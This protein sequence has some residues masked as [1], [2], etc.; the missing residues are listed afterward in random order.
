MNR[1]ITIF[2]PLTRAYD[3]A[4]IY[5][6]PDNICAIYPDL[7]KHRTI[8]DFVNNRIAVKEC[9]E[10]IVKLAKLTQELNNEITTGKVKNEELNEITIGKVESEELYES[11]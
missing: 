10:S 5:A 1:N 9:M 7:E 6:N 8:V 2:I 11:S 3:E 4:K